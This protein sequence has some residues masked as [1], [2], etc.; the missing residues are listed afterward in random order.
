MTLF[1]KC[2]PVTETLILQLSCTKS[3][4]TFPMFVKRKIEEERL[5][6]GDGESR[7]GRMSLEGR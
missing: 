1:K 4:C 7:G 2:P 6:R 3:V 5:Q